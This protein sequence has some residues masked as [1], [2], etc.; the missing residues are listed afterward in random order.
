[1]TEKTGSVHWEGDGTQGRGAI[2]TET[3]ALDAYPYGFASRFEGRRDG[4]NPEELLAAAH[5]AC[6]TMAFAF[7]CEKAGFTPTSIDTQCRARLTRVDDGFLID[8]LALTMKA[9]VSGMGDELFQSLAAK[10]KK[11]C[12]LSRA[13]ASVPVISL[14]ATL[15]PQP[16][17]AGA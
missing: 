17:P 2:T 16:E 4:T 14:E 1:M 13:L 8:Q 7:A 11:E 3:G 15:L 12:P 9:R 6:L 5:A 10:V